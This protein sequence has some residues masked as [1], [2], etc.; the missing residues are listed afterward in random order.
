MDVFFFLSKHREIQLDVDWIPC[1]QNVAADCLSSITDY[2]DYLVHDDVF[3]QL[4]ALWGPH[5]IDRFACS[6]NAKLPRFNSRFLQPGS[7]AV[8]AF[9]QDWA[10]ENNWLVPP[11]TLIGRVLRHMQDCKAFGTLIIPMWNRTVLCEDGMHFNLF[12]HAWVLLPS[13]PDLFVPGKAR[14]RLFGTK[15]FKSRCLA[16]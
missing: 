15:V 2:D 4:D 14:N 16:L 5:S 7:E 1:D 12:I 9:S 6:Y 10:L 8:D 13:R 3:M 11:V